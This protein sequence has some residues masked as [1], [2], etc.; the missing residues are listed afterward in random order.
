MLGLWAGQGTPLCTLPGGLTLCVVG[1][2]DVAPRSNSTWML[3]STLTVTGPETQSRLPPLW[4]PSARFSGLCGHQLLRLKPRAFVDPALALVPV[5]AG[6]QSCWLLLLRI[7]R[8]ERCRPGTLPPRYTAAQV[9]CR[10]GTL[11]PRY[12]AT[13]FE[14]QS[15]PG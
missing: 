9:H 1:H 8:S 3:I 10:P 12:A 11:P 7:S 14:P 13:Q 5:D 4:S 6:V 2:H 15:R